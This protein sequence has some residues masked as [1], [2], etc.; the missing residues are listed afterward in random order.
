MLS[1]SMIQYDDNSKKHVAQHYIKKTRRVVAL[2]AAQI[3][4]LDKAEFKRKIKNYTPPKATV[5]E[6]L[7]ETYRKIEVEDL[8]LKQQA[9]LEGDG[10]LRFIKSD[11]KGVR[12]GTKKEMEN[13]LFHVRSGCCQDPFPL[14]EMN[15]K[16]DPND[17]YSNY[18]RKRGTSQ[19]ESTNRLVNQL[20]AELSIQT[21]ELGHKK[22]YLRFTRLNLDKD[23]VLQKLLGIAKVRTMDWYI[24]HALLE[25][26]PYLTYYQGMDFP[27][28]LPPD[29][30]EPIGIEYGRCKDWVEADRK[31]AEW[32]QMKPR[33][34]IEPPV[35]EQQ[36]APT[37]DSVEATSGQPSNN[38]ESQTSSS[39]TAQD[40]GPAANWARNPTPMTAYQVSVL[41]QY[42][43]PSDKLNKI[44]WTYFWRAVTQ[45]AKYLG[46]EANTAS[47]AKQAALNWQAAH[48]HLCGIEPVSTG[49]G[50]LL[51]KETIKALL[52]EKGYQVQAA[53]MGGLNPHINNARA[54]VNR[55]G[56]AKDMV[57]KLSYADAGNWL[58]LLGLSILSTLPKRKAK[59][60]EYFASQPEGY[61]VYS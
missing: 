29:Y 51:R 55:K 9:E 17:D 2:E 36:P 31:L 57:D 38:A 47:V 27:P 24:Q 16:V 44:Q 3:S 18:I 48:L 10:Y 13:L 56:L 60:M 5:E 14:D 50:G 49:L 37:I 6:A 58:R 11:K 1:A 40:Y 52:I 30:Y 61:I 26:H 22:L 59:L 54:M 20:V 33:E 35:L 7:K 28:E 32:T 34:T 12:V 19:G 21:P 41:N 39:S 4:V 43:K 53:R 45:A 8:K 15:I 23:K 46:E 25:Q 42:L